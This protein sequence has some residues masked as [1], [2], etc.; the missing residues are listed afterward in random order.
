[1][2]TEESVSKNE[3][4]QRATD[5]YL[6]ETGS[7]V[8]TTRE[9]A[10]W[11]IKRKLSEPQP[12]MLVKQCAEEFA[13][14]LR[15]QYVT[16]PTGRRVR[17]KHVA[18]VVDGDPQ[19]PLWADI[20]TASRDHMFRAF[21]LRRQQI[22]GDCLQLKNDLDSYNQYYNKEGGESLQIIFDFTEDLADYDAL[23]A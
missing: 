15:E 19:I 13:K 2:A 14:A 4:M 18:L 20:R 23:A 16:D 7:T 9:L 1:M 12:A 21:Q 17:A 22:G 3:Q 8:F 10:A 11:A 5:Q 6:E